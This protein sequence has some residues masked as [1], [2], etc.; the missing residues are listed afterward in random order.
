ME[1]ISLSLVVNKENPAK[2]KMARA[3]RDSLAEK[4]I[5]V[6]LSELRWERYIRAL[7]N[8]EYDIYL[9]EVMLTADF[10]LTQLL[11]YGGNANYGVYDAQLQSLIYDFNASAE[12]GKQD[13]AAKLFSYIAEHLP[14]I[15]LMFEIETIYTHRETVSGM[16][17]T[18][19]NQFSN[20]TAWSINAE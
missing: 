6:T 13:A 2:I 7:K 19:H 10:D 11:S 9:G 12:E 16:N 8:R 14:V 3:L 1:E 18:I 15:S 20:I 17:P 4:G 5:T